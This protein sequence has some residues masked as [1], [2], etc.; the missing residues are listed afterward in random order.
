ML[1]RTIGIYLMGLGAGLIAAAT[2]HLP[3]VKSAGYLILW[4]GIVCGCVGIAFDPRQR[5]SS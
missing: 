4:I 5:K 2:F 1:T 3:V